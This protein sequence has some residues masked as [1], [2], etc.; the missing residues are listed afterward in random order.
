MKKIKRV[1]I[2]DLTEY[3]FNNHN[4]LTRNYLFN[5]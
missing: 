2:S 4:P 5:Y 1:S 3:L